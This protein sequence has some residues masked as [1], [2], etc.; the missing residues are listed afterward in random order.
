MPKY[1]NIFILLL[2]LTLL[3]TG[4]DRPE[5]TDDD[6]YF[7]VDRI[8]GILA[9]PNDLPETFTLQLKACIRSVHNPETTLPRRKF[10]ISNNKEL[11][12]KEGEKNPSEIVTCTGTENQNSNCQ[13]DNSMSKNTPVIALATEGDGCLQWTEEY[14][15]AYTNESKWININRYIQ[16]IDAPWIGRVSIPIAVNPWLQRTQKEEYSE[17]QIAD[18]RHHE[19]NNLLKDK[20]HPG[21]GLEYLKQ[22]KQTEKKTQNRYHSKKCQIDYLIEEKYR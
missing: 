2:T 1:K 13:S 21:D 9:I 22:A 15:Y 18:L 4:C 11:I 14:D 3:I 19:D 16:G 8:T 17:L 10:L 6:A 12:Q 7:A 5:G 20:I